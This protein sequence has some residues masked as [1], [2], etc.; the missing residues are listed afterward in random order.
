MHT[1]LSNRDRARQHSFSPAPECH[2]WRCPRAKPGSHVPGM[3]WGG[4]A[5]LLHC[6]TAEA[7]HF[8]HSC[9][10]LSIS[11]W[12]GIFLQIK[13]NLNYTSRMREHFYRKYRMKESR[14]C[15]ERGGDVMCVVNTGFIE[16]NPN[17]LRGKMSFKLCFRICFPKVSNGFFK[18]NGLTLNFLPKIIWC[19]I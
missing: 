11:N 2:Q 7:R 14:A 13:T 4:T 9:S 19:Q 18:G 1:V 3:A 16:I 5:V 15:G 10:R 6:G 17:H 12:R 8:S